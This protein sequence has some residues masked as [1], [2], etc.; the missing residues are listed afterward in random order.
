MA[1]APAFAS[2]GEAVEVVRAGL[3]FVAA[4]DAAGLTAEE[5]AGCLRGLEK[6]NSAAVAART[7]VLGAFTTGKGYA[8]DADYSARAWLMH[9][10]GIT[11]GASV[12]YTAW[13]RRAGRHPVIYA[14]LAAGQVSESCARTLCTWTDKLPPDKRDEA[15]QILAQEAGAGMGLR[16]LAGL[17]AE[18]LARCRP[19]EP[20]RD[21]DGAF[22]DRS[23]KVQTTFQGAGIIYGDLTPECASTVGTVLD[24]LAGRAGSED[25]RTREQRYHDALQ[26]AMRRLGFCIL[27]DPTPRAC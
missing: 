9:K 11:R 1:T 23:V 12:S 19:D 2:V 24:A 13:V 4:A 26:E 27:M 20:D 21:P 16:D 10:T 14:A 22:D 7:S 6:A 15:D 17:A 3:A 18:M 5:Q 8:A 25:G